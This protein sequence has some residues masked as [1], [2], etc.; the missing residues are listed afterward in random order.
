MN[1]F[2]PEDLLG[3]AKHKTQ[4]EVANGLA[5]KLS[6]GFSTRRFLFALGA[7]MVASGEKMK[8]RHAPPLFPDQMGLLLNKTR[9]HG[10]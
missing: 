7:W 4:E 10:V 6:H 3:I 1:D 9:K 5:W 2:D 8:A